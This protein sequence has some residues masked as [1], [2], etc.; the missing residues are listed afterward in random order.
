MKNK[1]ILHES[2]KDPLFINILKRALNIIIY[3]ILNYF[4]KG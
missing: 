1:M 3:H 4:K 2:I